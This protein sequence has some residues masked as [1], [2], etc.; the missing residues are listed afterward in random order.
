M[1]IGVIPARL[2]S[3]R[4]F[5]KILYPIFGKP[6]IVHVYDRAK[7]SKTLDSVKLAIDSEITAKEL[8]NFDIDMIMTARSHVSGSDR[9]GEVVEK[10]HADIVVNIQGDEPMIDPQIIDDL[11]GIFNDDAVQMA[12]VASTDLR[13][14]DCDDKNTVKVKIDKLGNAIGFKRIIKTNDVKNYFRHVGL[15]AYRKKQ[16]MDFI[17]LPPTEN[18][19]ELHLEQLRA[20]ENGI[21]IRTIIT[22]FPYRGVDAIED[23]QRLK[24]DEKCR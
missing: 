21:K 22:D 5:R 17:D 10:L 13:I 1:N 8:S 9:V 18:E 23:I 19:K 4:F 11:V 14:G 12:T 6:M 15:Y 3:T 24:L 16:L 20:I 2:E 7:Q